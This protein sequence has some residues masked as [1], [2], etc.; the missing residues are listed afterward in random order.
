MTHWTFNILTAIFLLLG[1][2]GY[3][4]KS[5]SKTVNPLDVII[6]YYPWGKNGWTNPIN[7]KGDTLIFIDSRKNE[8]R[9]Y[10]FYADTDTIKT[11]GLYPPLLNPLF[12]NDKFKGKYFYVISSFIKQSNKQTYTI[13][14]LLQLDTKD[15]LY[16][17]MHYQSTSRNKCLI[18]KGY[19]E[20]A[21]KN[22]L[23]REYYFKSNYFSRTF[24]DNNPRLKING[25]EIDIKKL[26]G[27]KFLSTEIYSDTSY[28]FSPVAQLTNNE[29]TILVPLENICKWLITKHEFNCLKIKYKK[30]GA[31][32]SLTSDINIGDKKKFV[33]TSMGIP[34]RI[35]QDEYKYLNIDTTS[36]SVLIFKEPG[37]TYLEYDEMW[38]YQK[39]PNYDI[40]FYKNKV[41]AIVNGTSY[42]IKIKKKLKKK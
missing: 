35:Y 40:F 34:P 25:K 20:Q 13:L 31:L 8:G 37:G 38:N 12:P 18:P 42:Y 9:F 7:L 24:V 39:N 1:H 17:P 21:K 29:Y 3:G 33:I 19:I 5:N 28:F 32:R 15:T 30:R 4:Q 26:S 36:K 16:Y 10:Y 6:N 27:K 22:L 11:N 23:N 2:F 14:K 41:V